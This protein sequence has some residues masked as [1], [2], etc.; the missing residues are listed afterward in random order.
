VKA[1]H[2]LDAWLRNPFFVLEVPVSASRAEVE[3]AGQKL[4]L[5]LELG[6]ARICQTPLGTLE[7]NADLVRASLATLRDPTTRAT[8]ALW[9]NVTLPDC[10]DQDENTRPWPE[11][12][13]AVGCRE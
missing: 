5:L 8:A 7:R 10:V 9:A 13:T 6:S 11:A 2:G 12:M 4:L 3:R 1:A